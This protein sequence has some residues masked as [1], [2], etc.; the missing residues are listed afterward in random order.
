M[1][2]KTA[3]QTVQS[4]Q[5]S[6][7]NGTTE[8]MDLVSEN[9]TFKGPVADVKGKKDFI[10]LNVGFLPS[11]RGYEPINSFEQGNFACLEGLYK[12]ASPKGNEIEFVMAEVY[13]VEKGIIQGVRVYYDA[14][15]F[16]KEFGN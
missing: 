1:S 2:T 3:M 15:E 10:E 4:F 8:W 6:L 13:T 11:V 14:E 9:V 5:M 12:I 16:R 7:G